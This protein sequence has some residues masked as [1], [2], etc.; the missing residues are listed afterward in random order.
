MKRILEIDGKPRNVYKLP[1]RKFRKKP[2]V[3]KAIRIFKPFRVRT[4][5]GIMKGNKGD[6]LIMGIKGEFYPCKPDIFKETYENNYETQK[7]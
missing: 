7:S 6:W 5:E 2:V 4:K 3:I 1:F